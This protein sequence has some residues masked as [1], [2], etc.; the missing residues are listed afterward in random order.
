MTS[1]QL[2]YLASPYSHPDP[3]IREA[4]YRAAMHVVAESMNDAKPDHALEPTFEFVVYSP[5]VHNHPI[6]LMYHLPAQ[7]AFWRAVDFPVLER[8][9]RVLVLKID[10]WG[11]SVG[12]FAEVSHAFALGKPVDYAESWSDFVKKS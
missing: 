8:C 1:T 4:R 10:G 6:S 5:V 9:D 2:I 12:V 7:W 11:R 3:R